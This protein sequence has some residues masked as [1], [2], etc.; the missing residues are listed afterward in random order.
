M[1]SYLV[2]RMLRLLST[3]AVAALLLQPALAQESSA[4][5]EAATEVELATARST[6]S[7]YED[8]P[9]FGGPEAVST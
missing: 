7:G 8:I 1:T 6:Q 2:I 3:I 9:E 5:E 4:D